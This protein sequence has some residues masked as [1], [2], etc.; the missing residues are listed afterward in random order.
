MLSSSKILTTHSQKPPCISIVT[1]FLTFCQLFLDLMAEETKQTFLN[2]SLKNMINPKVQQD[3]QDCYNVCESIS[4][5]SG[6][7]NYMGEDSTNSVGSCSSFSSTDLVEDASSSSSA[8]SPS[9]S[10]QANDG[11]LYELSELMAQLPIKR[12][13]SKFYKG[14]SQSYTS[15]ASVKSIEDLAKKV[16]PYNNRSKLKSCKSFAVLD[17]NRSFGPKATISKKVHSRAFFCNF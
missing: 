6:E 2:F 10:S 1:S 3:Y 12:G 17:S 13:L 15:L 5:S 11:P 9:S 8:S 4:S 14:K 16:N 7:S